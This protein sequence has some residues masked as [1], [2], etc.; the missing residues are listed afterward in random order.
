[1]LRSLFKTEGAGAQ[2]EMAL[3]PMSRLWRQAEACAA[4]LPP[5]AVHA[6]RRLRAAVR[7]VHAR[8]RAGPGDAFWQFRPYESG[9]AASGIDWRR[10]ARSDALYVRQQEWETAQAIWLWVD[11]S[12]S[13]HF[14][15][16]AAQAS[17]S[18]RA[19]VL[20]LATA[21]LL[22]AAG[23]RVALFGLDERP[24]S[25][26]FGLSRLRI[27]LD[28]MRT[29]DSGS[30]PEPR[31]IPRFSRLL[32]IGDFLGEEE[33]T[34]TALDRL[35]PLGVDGHMLQILDPVEEDF[36]YRGRVTFEGLENDETVL[37]NRS[38][39]LGDLYRRHLGAWIETLRNISRRVGWT[40]SLHRTDH[41]A[42]AALFSLISLTGRAG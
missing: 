40:H 17:K 38:D 3:T 11:G 9:E 25:G 22:V 42:A 10:S 39:G 14:R 2:A 8:R 5:Y 27:G 35:V 32:L 37:I 7:G 4:A 6:D 33:P 30:F 41:S 15:S 26:Q 18:D 12:P 16:E 34:R 24:A 1:M 13:M 23:E 29:T 19:V 28:L 20:A 21:K 36:P 31:A